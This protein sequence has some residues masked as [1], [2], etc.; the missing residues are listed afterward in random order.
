MQLMVS[1]LEKA[2]AAICDWTLQ[3]TMEAATAAYV[4][5]GIRLCMTLIYRVVARRSI[6]LPYIQ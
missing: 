3:V 1:E 5:L 2:V 4:G 6:T